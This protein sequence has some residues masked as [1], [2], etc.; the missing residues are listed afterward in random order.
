MLAAR[1]AA[2]QCGCRLVALARDTD[3]LGLIDIL[4]V[5]SS[6][7]L[8]ELSLDVFEDLADEVQGRIDRELDE[9]VVAR[10]RL[11]VLAAVA[12]QEEGEAALAAIVREPR[13]GHLHLPEDGRE[14]RAIR[15]ERHRRSVVARVV[16]GRLVDRRFQ[17]VEVRAQAQP[18]GVVVRRSADLRGIIAST[19]APST[20]PLLMGSSP[21]YR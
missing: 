2:H 16:A 7:Q 11:G 5:V 21:R 8:I 15:V 20:R 9:D 12:A 1:R 18:F 4:L 19:S 17:A 14:K 10:A 3:I 13:L 6:L